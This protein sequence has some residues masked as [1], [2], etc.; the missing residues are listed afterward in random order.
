MDKIITI[1][2]RQVGFRATALTPRLYRHRMGRD[3]IRDLNQLRRSFSK[4]ASFSKDATAEEREEA[5]LS[6]LDLEI[7]ENIAWLMARQYDPTVPDS[8]EEWLE[9]FSMF[10]IYT[11]MPE[12]L[13]L[14]DANQLTTAKPKKK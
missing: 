11:I 8:P 1:A 2:G 9:G 3:I 13:E 10:S 12:I 5:Q 14:W 6:M 4:A 7:F